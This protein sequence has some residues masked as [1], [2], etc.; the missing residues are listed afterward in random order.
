MMLCW[1]ENIE[2]TLGPGVTYTCTGELAHSK[3][4]L[5]RHHNE[6]RSMYIMRNFVI[7]RELYGLCDFLTPE[8]PSIPP[9]FAGEGNELQ[10]RLPGLVAKYKI[11]WLVFDDEELFSLFQKPGLTRLTV[12]VPFEDDRYRSLSRIIRTSSLPTNLST[13][14]TV[15]YPLGS[16]SPLPGPSQ[17]TLPGLTNAASQLM[18]PHLINPPSLFSYTAPTQTDT[19]YTPTLFPYTAPAKTDTSSSDGCGVLVLF[20]IIIFLFIVYRGCL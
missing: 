19:K 1:R 15:N 6:E 16:F 11:R 5:A 17:P 7:D 18:Y 10:T 12:L 8:S 4:V 2:Y 9:K 14:S 13:T 3:A 20:A